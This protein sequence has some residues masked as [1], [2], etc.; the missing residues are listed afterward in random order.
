MSTPRE[1]GDGYRERMRYGF[2]GTGVITRAMVIGLSGDPSTAPSVLL[3]P[4]N[5]DIAA[6]LAARFPNVTV[7][8]SNAE[9]V[10]RG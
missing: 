8:T 7:G 10:E 9:V 2:I 6:E 3:S 5:A 4:R 1:D